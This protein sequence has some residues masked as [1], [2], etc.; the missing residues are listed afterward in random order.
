MSQVC[1]TDHTMLQ[2]SCS[3]RSSYGSAGSA[4]MVALPS[5]PTC[6]LLWLASSP[7]SLLLSVELLGF[8]SIT[9]SRRS[10]PQS[11]SA[12]VLSLLSSLLPRHP[13][14]FC[15]VGSHLR[16]RGRNLCRLIGFKSTTAS[17]RWEGTECIFTALRGFA[18]VVFCWNG[19]CS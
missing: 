12:P 18:R 10:S 8:S 15:M 6:V 16:R 2:I 7:I 19:W 11:A 4:S 1:H 9:V 3:A 5:L 14:F 13:D 17:G